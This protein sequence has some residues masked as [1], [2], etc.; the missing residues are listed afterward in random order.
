V[1]EP[2]S[3]RSSPDIRKTDVSL[4]KDSL[5]ELKYLSHLIDGVV[6]II[7]RL[8]VAWISSQPTC[9]LGNLLLQVGERVALDMH[10]REG[11]ADE[12]GHGDIPADR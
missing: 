3:G 9:D 2:T 7:Q 11:P 5:V 6:E 1:R 10:A 4:G 8:G 12:M